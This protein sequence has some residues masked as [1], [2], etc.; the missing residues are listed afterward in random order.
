MNYD[1]Y[2]YIHR[3]DSACRQYRDSFWSLQTACDLIIQELSNSTQQLICYAL[4]R[5]I[6]LDI[7]FAFLLMDSGKLDEKNYY[8]I[9][10]HIKKYDNERDVMK[11]LSIK[12]R[13]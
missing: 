10:N 9:K 2:H 1:G 8:R 3:N 4:P 13:I 12:D 5:S 7:S 6:R 11:I